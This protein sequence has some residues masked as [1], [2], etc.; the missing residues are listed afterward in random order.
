VDAAAV[1]AIDADIVRLLADMERAGL[2][3][4]FP[5]PRPTREYSG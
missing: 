5:E 1:D 3:A 4:P 2:A